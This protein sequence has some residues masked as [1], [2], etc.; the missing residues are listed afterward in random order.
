M[1]QM[2]FFLCCA[3][4]LVA[5]S[6]LSQVESAEAAIKERAYTFDDLGAAAGTQPAVLGGFNRRGVLDSAPS[7]MDYGGVDPPNNFNNSLVPLIGS[8]NAARIPTYVSAA[9]RPGAVASNLGLSFD[10]VDDSLYNPTPP[11]NATTPYSFDPRNFGGR[12]EV[13]SQAWVK[14][15]ATTFTARQFVWRV[16]NEN[17]GVII[18]T[19]GK[20]ALRTGETAPLGEFFEVESNVAVQPNV[21][22]HLAVLRG[23]NSSLLYVNGSVV[24]LDTGFWGGD[25]PEVRL[26]S[27]FLAIGEDAYFKGVID[28]FNIGTASDGTFDPAVDLDFFTNQNITFSG[29]DGDVD[30]DGFVDVDDYN[31]WSQ[32]FGFNNLLGQG[33]PGTLLKGDVD[34]SGIVDFYDFQIINL[35]ALNPPVGAGSGTGIPEPLSLTLVLCGLGLISLRRLGRGHARWRYLAPALLCGVVVLA[36]TTMTHATVV[37]ADDF[38]YDGKSKALHVGGGFDG[39][40]QYRGGQNGAAGSWVGQWGQIGDGVI[41]TAEFVPPIDPFNELPEPMPPIN[42]GLYDGFFGVQSELFRDFQLAPSVPTTQTLYF[43]GKFKADLAIGTDGG[44]VPQFYAPRLFLN[45]IAGD[46]RDTD[47]DGIPLDPQRD[48]TQDVGLGFEDNMLVARL[49]TAGEVKMVVPTSAP[50]DG[51]WHT[52]VGKFEVNAVGANERLTVWIN[53]T[54]VESGGAMAQVQADVLP[55]LTTLVGTFHSQ[56]TVPIDPDN[57]ELGRSYIDDMAIGTAWQDVTTV[58]IPRLTLRIN[59]GDNTARLINNTSSTIQ[60]NGYSVESKNG[61][62][63]PVGW[64]SLDE[65]NNGTWQQNLATSHQ[66]VESNFLSSSTLSPNGGQLP[67]GNLFTANALEDL[68]GRFTTLDG[69]VNLLNVEF[70]TSVGLGGDYNNDGTVNAADYTLWRNHLNENFQLQNEGG[71]TPGI[72]NQADYDFWKS[73]FGMHLGSGGG[74]V[75]SVPEPAAWLLSMLALSAVAF[76]RRQRGSVHEES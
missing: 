73:Q 59:K 37:V 2:H 54:G 45:R 16:G 8:G 53:P 9:D 46:D 66:I 15:T 25:G 60:L 51:N 27:N 5:A 48:R 41:T 22:T 72:V 42:V 23:G 13:I 65:Q 67:L 71:I 35:A 52:I 58:N 4:V 18:T 44:T 14:P 32:N 36:G 49:G 43:G 10:G 34:Q 12:F 20:W 40:Q 24:A 74:S 3:C 19:N 62:I 47:S 57:P 29:V 76:R 50:N 69:L 68:T 6:V 38:Y 64:N 17:G 26:G 55:D 33:D 21:W 30:Q 7:T 75:Q 63:N 70:V 1:K 61:S 28:N 31:I 56:G 11:A 39:F